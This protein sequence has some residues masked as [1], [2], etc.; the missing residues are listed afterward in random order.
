MRTSMFSVLTAVL[1]FTSAPV[2]AQGQPAPG[3]WA[4]LQVDTALAQQILAQGDRSAAGQLALDTHQALTVAVVEVQA[5]RGEAW[6][7]ELHEELSA[8]LSRAGFQ[9]PPAP[10][11]D[12]VVDARD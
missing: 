11:R 12:A 7:G 3:P 6:V 2:F 8:V 4:W 5:A 1:L 10:G 9:V